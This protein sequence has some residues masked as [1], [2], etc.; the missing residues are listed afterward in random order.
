MRQARQGLQSTD[1]ARELDERAQRAILLR[2]KEELQAALEFLRHDKGLAEEKAELL[3]LELA[4]TR[5]NSSVQSAVAVGMGVSASH[6]IVHALQHE[7]WSIR[8]DLLMPESHSLVQTLAE[9]NVALEESKIQCAKLAASR[10]DAETERKSTSLQLQQV[11]AEKLQIQGQHDAK[12]RKILAAAATLN[13]HLTHLAADISSLLFSP[14]CIDSDDERMS[15]SRRSP[16]RQQFQSHRGM[17]KRRPIRPLEI[18]PRTESG[19][20]WTRVPGLSPCGAEAMAVQALSPSIGPGEQEGDARIFQEDLQMSP[21]ENLTCF[22]REVLAELAARSRFEIEQRKRENHLITESVASAMHELIEQLSAISIEFN[23]VQEAEISLQSITAFLQKRLLENTEELNLVESEL[24][25]SV[26]EACQLR[27]QFEH[28]SSVLHDLKIERQQSGEVLD[29]YRWQ[30][31]EASTLALDM[32]GSL[33]V[34]KMRADF[35]ELNHA[36]IKEKW[37]AFSHSRRRA[38][39]VSAAW[40]R[41]LLSIQCSSAWHSIEKMSERAHRCLNQV[42]LQYFMLSFHVVA[43]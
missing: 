41:W 43:R 42:S 37:I 12:T 3:T 5:R 33:E 17:S 35:H 34:Q 7:D 13:A 25:Q 28:Q 29:R 21:I 9:T 16:H 27:G 18:S 23:K 11:A 36:A 4:N 39:R 24:D 40:K 22:Q 14:V 8:E 2:E 6:R 30:Y 20:E 1:R 10:E 15:P 31:A 32:A 38:C 19:R 26:E